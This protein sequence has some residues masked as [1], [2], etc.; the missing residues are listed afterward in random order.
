MI[1]SLFAL[2]CATFF[3]VVS[4]VTCQVSFSLSWLAVGCATIYFVR[5]DMPLNVRYLI[6]FCRNFPCHAPPF[7]SLS[8][9]AMQCATFHFV[10]RDMTWKN[11]DISF[12][13][14]CNFPLSCATFH[15]LQCYFPWI[16]GHFIFFFDI[17]PV[18]CH[19]FCRGLL[20]HVPRFIFFIVIS[21][22][23]RDI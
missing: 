17:Q 12:F 13:F 7:I 15:F 3:V 5:R 14:R 11:C 4:S 2:S 21:P 22:G 1:P 8:W 10:R 20:C 16:L 9:F 6:C 18:M 23:M 19:V